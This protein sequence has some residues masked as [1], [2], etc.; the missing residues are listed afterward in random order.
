VALFID[1]GAV[2][3]ALGNLRPWEKIGSLK[4]RLRLLIFKDPKE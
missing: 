4:M 1:P 3:L 2:A